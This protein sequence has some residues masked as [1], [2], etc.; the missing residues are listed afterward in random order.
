MINLIGIS[1]KSKSGKDE[2]GKIIR[3]LTYCSETNQSM[4]YTDYS[5]LMSLNDCEIDDYITHTWNIKKFAGKVKE[6]I[7]LITGISIE[8]LEREEIK[9]EYLSNDWNWYI[10]RD[11]K[12]VYEMPTDVKYQELHKYTVRQM[13]QI[14]GT[15][16]FRNQFHPNTWIN[17]LF[18]DFRPIE[19]TSQ[20]IKNYDISSR[21]IITDLRFENESK[22]ILDRNGILIR[23]NRQLHNR[24][25]LD[26]DI[27]V[28]HPLYNKLHHESEISLDNYTNFNYTIK[29][30]GIIDDLIE[31]TRQIL[32]NENIIR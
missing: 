7:S 30:D 25:N 8:D 15:D 12:I 13:L 21:W 6:I 28:Q 22:A 32:I 26:A 1:G 18:T 24:Y 5:K 10:E 31:A 9:T 2:V 11:G 17:S 29:N 19:T 4:S 14:V 23:V 27:N 20:L 16:L 3:Y